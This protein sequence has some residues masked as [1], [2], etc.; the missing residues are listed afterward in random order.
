M[1]T[2]I[3]Y[4]KTLKFILIYFSLFS[5]S[6]NA[7]LNLELTQGIDTAIPIAV[8]P[9]IES[10]EI[11]DIVCA[12]L[13]NSGRFHLVN[14]SS[15]E[16]LSY[17]ASNVNYP[18]WLGKKIN[19][20]VIGTVASNWGKYTVNIQL[21]DIYGHSVLL[22]KQFIATKGQLRHLAHRISDLIYQQ[23]IG[24]RG[25]FS[26]KIA[27]V[28]IQK[29]STKQA[30]YLLMIADADGHNPKQLLVSNEPI[31]SPAWSPD[32]KNIAY[33][34]FEGRNSAIYIQ[35]IAT[36][37]RRILSKYSGING[38]PSWSPDGKSI[39]LVL[40]LTGYPKIY[41]IE[42]DTS[43]LQQITDGASL[44]TE[45]SW[46]PDGKS[47]VFTSN[48]GGSP[49]IYQIFLGSKS[50]KRLSYHGNYNARGSFT[51]NGKNI[52]MLNRDDGRFN[53]A[54]QDLKTGRLNIL[55]DLGINKSPSVAANG[56][57][58]AYATIFDGRGV[59]G[60]SSIDGRVKLRLPA[61]EGEV[62][63]PAWSPFLD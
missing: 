9:F 37:S 14:T 16:G 24:E 12:D 51:S 43:K 57:M 59:L 15:T 44:D 32:G 18:Y 56:S 53:I 58:V 36:G 21:L 38:A 63:D 48:S 1:T 17:A 19:N 29:K 27:Y 31:M 5:I 11:S 4:K 6:A 45:P 60:E 40:T 20:L 62:Q 35:N 23:L 26:T 8:I 13:S 30:K 10:P 34:S 28:V 54:V 22:N 42:L 61:Q 55:F 52:V 39:A 50:P 46:A 3:M 2:D 49:Q 33:V 47:I 25:I 7:A 41:T